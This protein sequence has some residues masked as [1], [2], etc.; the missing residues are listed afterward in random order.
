[1]SVNKPDTTIVSSIT[2]AKEDIRSILICFGTD[3]VH[4][5]LISL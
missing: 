3:G 2:E 4:S 1:M 5:G